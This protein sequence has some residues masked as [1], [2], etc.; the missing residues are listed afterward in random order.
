MKVSSKIIAGFLILMLVGL[1]ALA[2]QLSVIHQM[3]AINHDLSEINMNLASTALRMQELAS[4]VAE[5]SRKFLV[6]HDAIYERQIAEIRQEFLGKLE[7]LEKT[8]RSK[9]EIA[10]NEKLRSALT[11]YWDVFNRIKRQGRVSNRNYLPA[12]L[13]IAID[14]LQAQT[15]VTYEAVKGSVKDQVTR[16]A[17]ASEKAVRISW[18]AGIFSLILGLVVAAVIVGS[19]NEPLRRLT[20]GTRAIAKG[21]FWHRLP[22]DGHDEFS[23][24]ARDFN[25]M[26]ERLSE[27]DQM[28]KDFVSHVSH[29][30]KAP[31]ASMR[32][33]MHLLLQEIPGTLNDQQKS[34]LRLS[35]ASAERLAAMVGNLLDVARME[36]GS[37]EYEMAPHNLVPVVESVIEEFDVQARQKGI[38]MRLESDP[39]S[40]SADCDRDRIVQVLGNLFENGLKFSPSNSEIVTS[41]RTTS[42]GVLI[43][44]SD[45]GPGVPDEQKDKI[46]LKFHQVKR[47]KKVAGQG[48][49][50]GLAICKTIIEAHQGRIWV[51]DNPNGGSVFSF[52]LRPAASE[53]VLQCG[54]T[55]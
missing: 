55:A 30:L 31:L 48:V 21:Q 2:N 12:D 52:V 8:G 44:V 26:T 23:E 11:N 49:G 40:V 6:T 32:Q 1:V 17:D 7:I 53:E 10:E 47:G 29:D 20:Q 3:Q 25:V 38:R 18:A 43:S 24:V 36:A 14:H 50:L 4:I 28:K 34:L 51:Q 5:D 37:M 33:I 27:L 15:Q 9:R 22:A 19:I 39:R 41:V 16:A 54:Q 42:E 46:F 13:S 35:Y 45:S